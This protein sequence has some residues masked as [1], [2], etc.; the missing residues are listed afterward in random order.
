M[1]P[2]GLQSGMTT[3]DTCIAAASAAFTGFAAWAAWQASRQANLAAQQSNE[4]AAA[5]AQIERDRWHTEL[6]P[7]LRLRLEA[8]EGMLYIRFDGPA[9]L[10]HITVTL[11][12]R[13]DMDRTR[14]PNLGGTPTPEQV[15]EVIWGPYRFRPRINEAD[16][17]G[18]TMGIFTLEA[19][20]RTRRAVEPSLK[21][22][23][24]EDAAG[25]DRWRSQ[26]RSS[27]LRLWADCE[28]P[29]H[30]PWRLSFEV[31]QDGSWAMTGRLATTTGR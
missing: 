10:G 23:W 17:L 15:A 18:R 29:G 16:E 8:D 25:E 6:T 5:V 2:S 28:S 19:N 20:D 13:D 3:A 1:R 4:T 7:V 22:A 11:T 27:R 30:K 14:V 12:L 9:S 26:Y 31:P 24:Y 21:P